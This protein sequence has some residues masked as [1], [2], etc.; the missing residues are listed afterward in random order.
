MGGWYI[1]FSYKIRLDRN[2]QSCFF[3]AN[4]HDGISLYVTYVGRLQAL[5]KTQKSKELPDESGICGK[6][7]TGKIMTP[8]AGG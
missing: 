4:G 6:T 7:E 2:N 5:K 8:C 1:I 3:I